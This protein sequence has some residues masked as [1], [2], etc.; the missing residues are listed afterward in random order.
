M[1]TKN[2]NY[3]KCIAAAV[4][5][6]GTAASGMAVA[7]SGRDVGAF[8]AAYSSSWY[9]LPSANMIDPESRFGTNER[10]EG[11]GIRFGKVVSPAWDIQFGTTYSS[12]SES[13][14]NYR[15]NTLGIDAVYLFSRDRFRPLV[16]IGGGAQYD[17]VRGN[18][19]NADQTSP[20]V[21][22][23]LGFQYSFSPQ[24]G[25]QADVRR[26][27][28]FLDGDDFGFDHANTDILTVGFTYAFDKPAPRTAVSR[29]SPPVASPEPIAVVTPPPS[30]A[31]V[32]VVSPPPAPPRLERYTLSSTELF[33]FDSS[34]LLLPQP[35]L[36]EIAS[37]LSRNPQVGNV[38]VTGYTDRL[39]S[40]KY[41][42]ALSQR[43]AESVKAYIAGKGVDAGRLTAAGKGEQD[44]VVQC[45]DRNRADLIR[46]LQPNRRVE[47]EQI[48]LER[49]VP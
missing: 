11:L 18:R 43:R 46:C 24:W 16:L 34:T 23:G 27:Y 40:D 31:P 17:R 8:N 30:P 14:V 37:A 35:K 22:A 33:A 45:N 10:G 2:T 41:N 19:G 13:N 26:S 12:V 4:M 36:D 25:M 7:Q 20:Y 47:V 3:V 44:P 28:A 29:S 42:V 49:R 5:A 21:N 39:G 32:P 38:A 48:V 1:K 6:L 15:Q 9:I